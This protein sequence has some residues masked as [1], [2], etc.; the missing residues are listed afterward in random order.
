MRIAPS[1]PETEKT[2]G[3]Q[4]YTHISI[5][6]DDAA[7]NAKRYLQLYYRLLHVDGGSSLCTSREQTNFN[8]KLTAYCAADSF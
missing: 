1:L 4:K 6:M 7:R 8:Y 5:S 3:V 2:P